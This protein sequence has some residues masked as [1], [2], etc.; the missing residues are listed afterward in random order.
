M[1]LPA[2]TA[3]VDARRWWLSAAV[4]CLNTLFLLSPPAI[5][6]LV[7]TGALR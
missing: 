2:A 5:G 4:L 3:D 1:R 6:L 7:L